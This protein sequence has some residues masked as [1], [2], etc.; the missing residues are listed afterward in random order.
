MSTAVKPQKF[1]P[2]A[3]KAPGCGQAYSNPTSYGK[4]IGI[5]RFRVPG[6]RKRKDE[7]I[8]A[9]SRKRARLDGGKANERQE[10]EVRLKLLCSR[11]LSAANGR[12]RA[13]L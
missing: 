12:A 10:L 1:K 11:L 13:S 7:T 8:A 5:C 2:Y 3:C 4:H 9:Q 6:I